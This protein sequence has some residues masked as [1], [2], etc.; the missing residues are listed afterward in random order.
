MEGATNRHPAEDRIMADTNT[1]ATR[2]V[3]GW[4]LH[5]RKAPWETRWEVSL[6]ERVL[7]APT[8]VVEGR[9]EM[10]TMSPDYF[11]GRTFATPAEG[12]DYLRQIVA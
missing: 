12:A 10:A 9:L 3:V 11:E 8:A 1:S 4:E 6:C 2:T 5:L 7:N